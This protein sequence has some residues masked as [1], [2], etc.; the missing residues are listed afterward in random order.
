MCKNYCINHEIL[1]NLD[2]GIQYQIKPSCYITSLG[3]PFC[4]CQP[5]FSGS[6]CE[7]NKCH[8][9][10]MNGGECNF[11]SSNEP[12]CVCKLDFNGTRC[13]NFS[14]TQVLKTESP[15]ITTDEQLYLN[16]VYILSIFIAFYIVVSIVMLCV[17]Y[18]R[19]KAS[20]NY[21]TLETIS[22]DIKQ[23][24]SPGR[25]SPVVIKKSNQRARVFSA[26]HSKSRSRSKNR[27]HKN[28]LLNSCHD[29]DVSKFHTSF[30]SSNSCCSNGGVDNFSRSGVVLDLEDCCQMTLCDTVCFYL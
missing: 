6:R 7:T 23:S 12:K 3:I 27:N 8:N 21:S 19:F 13:Q 22:K 17:L 10:C 9:F 20:K 16:I 18:K 28:N 11:D 29:N 25:H 4:T 30:N 5:G 24:P 15:S 26:S 14:S 2:D 1:D